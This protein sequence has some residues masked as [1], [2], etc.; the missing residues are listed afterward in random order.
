[1]TPQCFFP[2]FRLW[3]RKR[4]SQWRSGILIWQWKDEERLT[5]NLLCL[6]LYLVLLKLVICYGF[7]YGAWMY[8]RNKQR[9]LGD[10]GSYLIISSMFIWK[11]RR[12]DAVLKHLYIFFALSHILYI[13][14]ITATTARKWDYSNGCNPKCKLLQMLQ[15]CCWK[16]VNA[17]S[18][19]KEEK[20]GRTKCHKH[21]SKK[22]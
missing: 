19:K 16:K 7:M 6:P 18:I 22:N 15:R 3:L 11:K 10:F 20:E 17:W 21:N 1:M 14:H 5:T 9:F 4:T 8:F 12:T 13:L 2:C